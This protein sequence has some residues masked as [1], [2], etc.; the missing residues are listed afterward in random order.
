[1]GGNMI[2]TRCKQEIST[3]QWW[4]CL[5]CVLTH[6]A[7]CMQSDASLA[8]RDRHDGIVLCSPA[9]FADEEF[10]DAILDLKNAVHA[11][12][13]DNNGVCSFFDSAILLIIQSAI[14]ADGQL[15]REFSAHSGSD[16]LAQYLH[17][18]IH[19]KKAGRFV[20]YFDRKATFSC[21]LSPRI[22]NQSQGTFDGLRW[23]GFAL[24]KSAFDLAIY[25]QMLS[26]F[27]PATV[28]EIGSGAGGSAVWFADMLDCL[29]IQNHIYTLDI[30]PVPAIDDRVTFIR[31]DCNQIEAAFQG[32]DPEF[33]PHPWLVIEDAHVNVSGI[34]S[35]FDGFLQSGDYIVVEDSPKKTNAIG[36]FLLDKRGRYRVDSKYTDMFGHNATTCFDSILKRM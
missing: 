32:L 11:K 12:I 16:P 33:W 5:D 8:H 1:M 2:C 23:K 28:I 24:F 4:L 36:K 31:G 9:A 22:H 6:C 20:D 14:G 25:Q 13:N 27:R 19:R 29:C 26:D 21:D 18:L 7:D 17:G 30:N 3:P 10:L 34:L 35:Y 15:N